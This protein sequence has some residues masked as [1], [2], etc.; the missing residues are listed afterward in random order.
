MEKLKLGV[1]YHGNRIL[2][3]VEEDMADITKHGMNVVV[4]MF[5]HNDWDRHVGVMKDIVQMSE[6]QGLEVWIDNW[7]LGGP[8][9]DKSHFLQYHPEAHQV[10]S[11]GQP[12]PVSA[13]YNSEAF[14]KFTTDWVDTVYD[15]G[16]RT[17]MWDEPRFKERKATWQMEAGESEP[18][19]T[20]FCSTCKKLFEERYNR[21]MPTQITPELAEF[22]KWTVENY[23]NRVTSHSAALGMKNIIAIMPRTYAYTLGLMKLPHMDNF[24]I[25]PYWHPENPKRYQEPYQ[26][27][28]RATVDL[29]ARTAQNNKE[30]HVWIQGYQIPAGYEDEIITAADAAFDAGARTILAW[31]YRGGESNTYRSEHCDRVWEAMG[32]AAHRLR[33]R[34][35]DQVRE[36]R[37]GT[38]HA[39]SP[40]LFKR[41]K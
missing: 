5:S 12:D 16:G 17:I 1:A 24:G 20:C 4:H 13:C 27:V 31:S 32:E 3:H 40:E 29:L 41:E 19:F 28:Y 39:Q 34:W 7:G 8:P 30:N 2:R 10:Y 22:R 14:V 35:L 15:F 11:D 36:E 21:P 9:G 37:L 38:L 25:D 23:F 6:A 33:S 18:E 26:F